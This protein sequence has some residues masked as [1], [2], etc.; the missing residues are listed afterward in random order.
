VFDI[1]A[2]SLFGEENDT[3][4]SQSFNSDESGSDEDIESNRRLATV[5]EDIWHCENR[6]KDDRQTMA[7][8]E[9]KVESIQS[10]MVHDEMRLAK[11]SHKLKKTRICRYLNKHMNDDGVYLFRNGDRAMRLDGVFNKRAVHARWRYI[12]KN[13]EPEF[14]RTEPMAILHGYHGPGTGHVLSDVDLSLW[15]EPIFG[16]DTEFSGFIKEVDPKDDNTGYVYKEA[17]LICKLR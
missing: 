9:A 3:V 6:L 10:S 12:H 14:D 4:S 15:E 5:K 7:V 1:D 8:Y 17:Y 13:D 16:G 2:L 11:W